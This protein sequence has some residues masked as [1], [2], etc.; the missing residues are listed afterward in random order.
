MSSKRGLDTVIT[1]TSQDFG[2]SSNETAGKGNVEIPNL[3]EEKTLEEHTV[4]EPNLSKRITNT[5]RIIGHHMEEITEERPI[6]EL[7]ETVRTSTHMCKL[8]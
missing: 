2:T 8:C 3:I 5:L 6:E 4:L 7:D 1:M